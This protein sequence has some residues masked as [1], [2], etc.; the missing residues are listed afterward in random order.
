MYIYDQNVHMYVY[1]KQLAR[2][3]LLLD[4]SHNKGT[5]GEERGGRAGKGV[6]G[7]GRGGGHSDCPEAVGA[8]GHSSD[9]DAVSLARVGGMGYGG[10]EVGANRED[11]RRY[12]RGWSA[13]GA[14]IGGGFGGLRLGGGLGEALTRA[15]ALGTMSSAK[16]GVCV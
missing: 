15:C 2:R 3:D 1:Q 16:L 8:R 14:G 4:P 12:R 13:S 11:I 5:G 9:M 6:G 10:V 7:L